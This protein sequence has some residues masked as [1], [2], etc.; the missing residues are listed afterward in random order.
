MPA[1]L[2]SIGAALAIGLG[3]FGAATC[4]GRAASSALEGIAR[5]PSV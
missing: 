3:A 4:Q 2:A 5:N 1:G